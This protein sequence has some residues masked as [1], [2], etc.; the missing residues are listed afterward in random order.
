MA[1]EGSTIGGLM[2]TIGTETSLGLQYGVPLRVFVDKFSHTRFEPSGWT[3]EPGHPAR[4]E[5][6][7]LHL[8]LAGDPVHSRLPRGQHA[9][10]TGR[11][12]ETQ[13]RPDGQRRPSSRRRRLPFPR[14]AVHRNGTATEMGTARGS[15]TSVEPEL[16]A[17]QSRNP[18]SA[19][20]QFS[21]RCPCLRQLRRNHGPQWQLLLVPQ[22]WEQH[23]M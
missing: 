3:H 6:R 11:D 22:L 14:P 9:A 7:R 4:Q 20:R 12:R 10:A 17:E 21:D 5:R 8:P 18:Q 13:E 1:K 2:D 23:G 19:V 15:I 16:E